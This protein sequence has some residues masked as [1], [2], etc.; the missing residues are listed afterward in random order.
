MTVGLSIE[1]F[2]GTVSKKLPPLNSGGEVICGAE[3]VAFGGTGLVRLPKA[4]NADD[5]CAGG[6]G[7][8]ALVLLKFSPPK[9]SASP[10]K[11][12][13]VAAGGEVIPPNDGSGL[14]WGW[15]AG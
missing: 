1:V 11:A 2:D 5:G 10:P 7:F 8:A 3:G 15:G 6:A 14:C 9:A 13:P 4:E 12:S